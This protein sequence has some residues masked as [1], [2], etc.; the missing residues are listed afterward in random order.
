MHLLRN[1]EYYAC[2]VQHTVQNVA[3]STGKLSICTITCHNLHS[4]GMS[5][6]WMSSNNTRLIDRPVRIALA[7]GGKS[8]ARRKLHDPAVDCA[9]HPSTVSLSRRTNWVPVRR[10][11]RHRCRASTLTSANR[12]HQGKRSSGQRAV[13]FTTD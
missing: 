1:V 7:F 11:C 10:S 3:L 6:R 8:G 2:R 12:R 5:G 9:L 4:T 13:A